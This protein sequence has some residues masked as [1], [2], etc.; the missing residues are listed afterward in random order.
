[1]SETQPHG[2]KFQHD[3]RKIND[4]CF[5]FAYGVT[6]IAALYGLYIIVRTKRC[7]RRYLSLIA[8]DVTFLVTGVAAF[9]SLVDST[10]LVFDQA[11]LIASSNM[12][13]WF[14]CYVYLKTSVEMNA[15]LDK[16]IHSDNIERLN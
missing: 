14:V 1:M 3:A 13:H 8:L 7:K 4:Y 6:I 16:R 5:Y 11:V 9:A 2:W 15:L 12:A 10:I